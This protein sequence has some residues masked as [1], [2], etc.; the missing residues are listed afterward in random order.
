MKPKTKPDA[1]SVFA[2]E[3]KL[4]CSS[5]RHLAR[6][7]TQCVGIVHSH[8]LRMSKESENYYCSI[9][10]MAA[11]FDKD[12]RTIRAAFRELTK[13]GFFEVIRRENGKAVNYRPLGH[14]EWAEKH[15]GQC[16]EKLAMPWD[17]ETDPLGRSLYSVS[18]A[19]VTF[20][21]NVLKGLRRHEF[22]DAEIITEWKQFLSE[23]DPLVWR[24]IIK[25]FNEY[26]PM[27]KHLYSQRPVTSDV[28]GTG[29]IECQG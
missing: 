14:T 27:K 18:G 3:S 1:S 10:Q 23:Q 26:L 16:V 28:G 25:R 11:Y 22:T 29:Y 12:P 24:G 7:K 6:L 9:P 4:H 20:F 5:E 8:A 21:P 15:P 2:G 19:R 13:L 17:G